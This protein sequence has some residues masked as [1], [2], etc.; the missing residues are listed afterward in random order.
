M[1]GIYIH[2]PFCHVK[3]AYCDFYSVANPV[4][5]T[6]FVDALINEYRHRSHELAGH[7]IETVYFGGG[8]PS[9]LAPELLERILHAIPTSDATEITL[10]ANPEDIDAETVRRWHTMGFNRVSIGV[11]SLND[12]ELKAVRRR[13]D[14]TR[15]LEAIETLQDGGITNISADLI[16]GLP[17]QT[18]ES[19]HRSL[20]TL[21]ATGIQHLSAYCLSYEPGTLLYRQLAEHRITEA[22]DE[23]IEQL[24]NDLCS[25][26]A[27]HGFEH[28]EISNFARP[29]FRARHN[30]SYWNSTPYLGLGPA[31]HSYTQGQRSYDPADLKKY[32]ATQGLNT[33]V[34]TESE[35]EAI[36][37]I[38]I[39]RLRT[40]DGLDLAQIPR[41]F[42][43][44][45]ERNIKPHIAAK[46]IVKKDSTIHIPENHWLTS[47]AILRDIIL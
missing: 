23:L 9:M 43:S 25:T 6:Q 10:E 8:T 1:A 2:I 18:P 11:Q 29:D 12:D 35:E 30:S 42:R 13:H 45:I 47:D 40:S 20:A 38:I 37:D 32:I 14:A 31:A 7:T 5:A 39:T 34:E 33:I 17:G 27:A 3:C 26:A 22:S 15:A 24:Y 28:Y 36:N 41:P 46:T 19:W 16:Y 21:L 44:S 4:V